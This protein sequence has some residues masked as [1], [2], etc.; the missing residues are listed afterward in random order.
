MCVCVGGGGGAGTPK[1]YRQE[2][3]FLCS[4]RHLMKLYISM[5]YHENILNGFQITERTQNYNCRISKGE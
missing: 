5:M 3:R 1:M 4:A 2:L